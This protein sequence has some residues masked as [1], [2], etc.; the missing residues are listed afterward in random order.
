MQAQQVLHKLLDDI[1]SMVHKTRRKALETLVMAALTGARLTVTDL[2]RAIASPVQ[3]KHCIK[4]ADR[5]LSNTHLHTEREAIYASLTRLF[6][7][8]RTRPVIIVDWSDLDACKRHF[9]LRASLALEGRALTLYEEVHTVKRKEKPKT[10]L[11][12]LRT[13]QRMLPA[14]CRPIIVSDAG[15]RVPW[16]K[17]VE[18]FG[19]DWIGR[20]RSRTFVQLAEDETWFSCKTLHDKATT[21]PKALGSARI[22]ESN[23]IDCQLVLYKAKPKG[24]AHKNRSGQKAMNAYSR[25]H[26]SSAREPWLLATSLAPGSTLARRVVAC[27]AWRMQIEGSF[28]DLKSTR[29][30]LSLEL[31]LTYQAQRLEVMLLIAAMALLVAWLMGKAAELTEQHWQYQANT[32]RTRK[33]LSTIFIGLKSIADR[34][35]TLTVYDLIAAWKALHDIIQ[36]NSFFEWRDEPENNLKKAA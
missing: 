8:S 33:V 2:G 35:I 22:T 7:G 1:G 30:G 21:M 27:Y 4:R 17:Q 3:P 34:R 28:R 36:S 9:L 29:F 25:K 6:V 24:R 5:L 18:S 14:G 10:H 19:W 31:H 20:I 13:L 23:P 32:V 11:E 15:F 26:A 16:F 12:F